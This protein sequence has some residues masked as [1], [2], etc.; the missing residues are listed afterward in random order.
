MKV[1]TQ[2][3]VA[4]VCSL[5]LLVAFASYFTF[6]S[7]RKTGN[8]F[9]TKDIKVI[10]PFSAGGGA[11]L[12]MRMFCEAANNG[13]YF[14]N[15]TL[16][17][18]NLPGG[19]AVIGQT[20]AFKANPDGYTML[21]YTSSLINNDIFNNVVYKYDDFK[22]LAGYCSDPEVL[23]APVKTSYN[24]LEEF[25]EYAK[26]HTVNVSTPGHTTGHHIRALAMAKKHGF[27]FNYLHSD[28]AAVQLQQVM[29]GH[30]DLSFTTVGACKSAIQDGNVKALAVMAEERVEGLPDVPTFKEL[31]ENLVDGAD[32]GIAVHK[33]VPDDIYQYLCK[34]AHKV[35]ESKE[36]QDGMKKMGLFAP[37]KTS[38]QYR[39]YMDKTYN[40]INE[41]LPLLKN[42]VKK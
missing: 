1:K 36:F 34:E 33:D 4:L 11:D 14:N 35:I 39:G 40:T 12:S 7:D 21:L 13:N 22:P 9:P 16:V 30:C 29:G 8:S 17:P 31:G 18:E 3:K 41:L 37:Y 42:S 32:R 25:Y 27:H 38:E 19:G 6:K 10:I 5:V 2:K 24:T 26:T 28:G 15:V 23:V 20:A